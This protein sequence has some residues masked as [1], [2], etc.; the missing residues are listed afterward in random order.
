MMVK[1]EYGFWHVGDCSKNNP[2]IS[3]GKFFTDFSKDQF[4]IDKP[5]P[6]STPSVF[7]TQNQNMVA[8]SGSMIS[9]ELYYPPQ[10]QNYIQPSYVPI[11]VPIEVKYPSYYG[12]EAQASNLFNAGSNFGN[13]G[14]IGTSNN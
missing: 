8:G 1:T 10:N 9:P 14:F 4:E 13:Q 3:E 7:Q 11:C 12:R 6:Q 2:L 5:A